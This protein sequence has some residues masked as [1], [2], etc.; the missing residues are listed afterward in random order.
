[1]VPRVCYLYFSS[2]VYVPLLFQNNA[3]IGTSL[4]LSFLYLLFLEQYR[5]IRDPQFIVV[6]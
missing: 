4:L 5:F 6:E 2:M 1:M 3:I